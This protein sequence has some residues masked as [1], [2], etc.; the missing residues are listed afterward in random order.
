MERPP[1]GK[2]GQ[3]FIFC[4]FHQQLDEGECPLSSVYAGRIH[5]FDSKGVQ[6]EGHFGKRRITRPVCFTKDSEA[7][8]AGDEGRIH[9]PQD[10]DVV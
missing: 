9:D 5:S 4:L 1:K 8:E 10:P 2:T 7:N 6:L 3:F